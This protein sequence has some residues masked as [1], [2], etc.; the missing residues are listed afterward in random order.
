MRKAANAHPNILRQR[1][2][3]QKKK[4]GKQSA[5]TDEL[6]R[7]AKCGI[8]GR[9]TVLGGEKKPRKH[10]VRDKTVGRQ[11]FCSK[12]QQ[13]NYS[14]ILNNTTSLKIDKNPIWFV[15]E[16]LK[17]TTMSVDT[18]W[19]A[20]RKKPWTKLCPLH[21]DWNWYLDSLIL[22]QRHKA[23]FCD[24]DCDWHTGGCCHTH[25][26]TPKVFCAPAPFCPPPAW[27]KFLM[28]L[29]L[30]VFAVIW[31]TQGSFGGLFNYVPILL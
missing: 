8:H 3:Q 31:F 20:I 13:I 23:S 2:R 29:N 17:L 27:S 26:S 4:K 7:R 10:I 24:C 22:F 30:L 12:T 15:W 6:C 16:V 18:E 5:G 28:L 1:R 14:L 9:K 25:S 21:L 19:T 11:Y